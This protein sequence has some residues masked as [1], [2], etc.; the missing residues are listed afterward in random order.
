M[1][2]L[3]TILN[4]R[5]GGAVR[6]VA[7][8]LG[9]DERQATSAIAALLPALTQGMK[10]NTASPG[11][12]EG[13]M[14]AL[15]G[16]GHQRYLDDPSTLSRPETTAD[17]NAIL[18]H[19]LGSKDVSRQV[20]GRAA[21]QTGLDVGVL[22]QALPLVATLLMGSMS[23]HAGQL[24]QGAPGAASENLLGGLSSLLDANHDGSVADDLMGFAK[25]LF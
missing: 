6:E 1:D 21:Q 25:K 14:G 23:R 8:S 2:L 12:L 4:A 20:A 9:L 3:S 16:G 7:G 15:T 18:G 5:Q 19:L 10:R 22:K 24:N 13:L 17:G 11:G